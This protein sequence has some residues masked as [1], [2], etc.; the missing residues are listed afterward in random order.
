M[1]P[2]LQLKNALAKGI[3][4]SLEDI[5]TFKTGIQDDLD[6]QIANICFKTLRYIIERKVEEEILRDQILQYLDKIKDNPLN[7][8][9]EFIKEEALDFCKKRKLSLTKRNRMT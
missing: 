3:A 8:D 7:G 4:K 9:L 2:P 1:E 5:K 6:H